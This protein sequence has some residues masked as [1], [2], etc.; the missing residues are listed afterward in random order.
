M[1][2]HVLHDNPG[3]FGVFAVALDG[4]GIAYEEVRYGADPLDLSQPPPAGVYWSRASASAP[5]RGQPDA[6]G[7]ARVT[8]A[9]LAASNRRVVNGERAFALEVSKAAQAVALAAHGIDVPRTVAATADTLVAA[10]KTFD[11][12]FVLKPD[13]GGKGLGVRLFDDADALGDRLRDEPAPVGVTLVQEYVAPA[14]PFVTRAE[15]VGGELLYTLA[16]DT[17]HG[18]ELCP[19][20][21]CAADGGPLFRWRE[22]VVPPQLDAYLAFAAAHDIEVAG[23]EYLEAADGRV[24]TY[25]VNT[26]TN[27]NPAVEARAGRSGPRAVAAYLGRLLDEERSR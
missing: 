17:S 9:W 20:E 22:G 5:A 14:Q 25:D 1:L 10:A 12:P 16:A 13:Q 3:W 4:A 18:F 26:T 24:L 15:I 6:T 7:A 8:L 21:A 11:G 2:L 27:Y 19:A 23:F